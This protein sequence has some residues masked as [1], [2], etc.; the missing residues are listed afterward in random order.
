M[1]TDDDEGNVN[2]SPPGS[3]PSSVEGLYAVSKP[4]HPFKYDDCTHKTSLC[5]RHLFLI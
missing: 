1:L 5:L 4:S 3:H 2:A